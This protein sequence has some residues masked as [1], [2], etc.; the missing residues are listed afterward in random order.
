VLRVRWRQLMNRRMVI[1][2]TWPWI[3]QSDR[4]M[5]PLRSHREFRASPKINT[6][7]T[8]VYRLR[9]AVRNAKIN[10]E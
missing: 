6:T 4:R 9:A 8:A 3:A 5:L 10:W 7:P 2:P 1:G